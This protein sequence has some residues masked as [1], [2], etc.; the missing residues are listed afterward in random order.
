MKID[1]QDSISEGEDLLSIGKIPIC[2]Q[3]CTSS[4]I[5]VVVGRMM[6]DTRERRGRYQI[7]IHGCVEL[8]PLGIR[9]PAIITGNVLARSAPCHCLS[10]QKQQKT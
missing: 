2:L 10:R 4:F 1:G 5:I 6:A 7:S 8:G 3:L 9:W